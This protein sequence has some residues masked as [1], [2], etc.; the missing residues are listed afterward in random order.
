M[1]YV[2]INNNCPRFFTNSNTVATRS[3]ALS[4]DP[5]RGEIDDERANINDL[6]YVE[7]NTGKE[8]LD[9]QRLVIY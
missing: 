2:D 5:E 3:F 8:N 9:R 6:E 7:Q 1:S 4:C